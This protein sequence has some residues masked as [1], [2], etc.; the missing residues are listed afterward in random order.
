MDTDAPCVDLEFYVCSSDRQFRCNGL[1]VAFL[2]FSEKQSTHFFAS[3]FVFHLIGV[4]IMP[5]LL[6][7]LFLLGVRRFCATG[8]RNVSPFSTHITLHAYCWTLGHWMRWVRS[9]APIAFLRRRCPRWS[10]AVTRS[11]ATTSRSFVYR[12]IWHSP[13]QVSCI[14][15]SEFHG[16]SKLKGLCKR[17][18]RL[19]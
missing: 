13:S 10:F 11:M 15:I 18:F 4:L 12:C 9:T 17:K 8:P 16:C 1:G 7:I 14:L 6:P 5:L 19:R 3:I 2:A